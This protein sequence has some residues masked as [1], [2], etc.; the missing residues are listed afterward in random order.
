[1]HLLSV[2]RL[3]GLFLILGLTVLTIAAFTPASASTKDA[4]TQKETLLAGLEKKYANRGF[5]ADFNQA[6]RLVALDITETATGKAWFTHPGK[7]RWLYLAPDRHEIIT[8][9]QLM[10]IYRPEENQV[11][12]GTA[13]PFFESGAGGAFLSD[14]TRIQKDFSIAL[15]KSEADFAQL[16]LTPKKETQDLAVIRITIALPSHEIQVVETENV[17]G[18][19]T[20]FVFTNIRFTPPDPAMFQFTIPDGVSVIEM[21]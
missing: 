14:I 15:G 6:A 20:R 7:M 18:D 16:I 19:T 13:A 4:T 12:R 10:W 17:Y 1:M 2:P 21:N 9:G 11:M 3:K 8:D 5:S